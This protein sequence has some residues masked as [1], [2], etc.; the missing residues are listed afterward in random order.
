MKNRTEYA[1]EIMKAIYSTDNP[2]VARDIVKRII[3]E[4]D[5]EWVAELEER[6]LLRTAAEITAKIKDK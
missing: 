1:S 5:S 3:E 2:S 4:V 6:N